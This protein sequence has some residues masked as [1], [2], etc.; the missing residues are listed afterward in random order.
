MNAQAVRT[1]F[2]TPQ[3]LWIAVFLW[4]GILLSALAVVYVTYDSRVRF[5]EL[6]T[7]RREQNQLQVV[8]GQYLLE[9]SAWAAYNRVEKLAV[10]KLSMQVPSAEQTIAVMSNEG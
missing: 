1:V 10:D 9:E 5:N 4:L 8:W 6:E 2:S 3:S 7:L